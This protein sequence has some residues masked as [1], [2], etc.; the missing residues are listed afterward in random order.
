[1]VLIIDVFVK[2]QTLEQYGISSGDS[3]LLINGIT[4][5][6]ETVDMFSLYDTIKNDL[7][8][9]DELSQH[10]LA[11]SCY[12]ALQTFYKRFKEQLLIYP[13]EVWSDLCQQMV[14]CSFM[15]V[16]KLLGAK[17]HLESFHLLS[18]VL[19]SCWKLGMWKRLILWCLSSYFFTLITFGILLP[20]WNFEGVGENK[21]WQ[22][23]FLPIFI[24]VMYACYY[25]YCRMKT[26]AVYYDSY[27]ILKINSLHWISGILQSL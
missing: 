14:L 12:N 23:T 27:L 16:I 26:L 3:A 17:Y 5:D 8:I 2:W 1:M 9:M 24:H 25:C 21:L 6:V 15:G 19:L 11:V 13:Q 20:L 18:I 7:T 22:K 10:G 4:M